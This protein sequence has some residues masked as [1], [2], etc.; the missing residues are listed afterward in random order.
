MQQD[1]DR[2]PLG[3]CYQ[4]GFKYNRDYERTYLA[5]RTDAA[6]DTVPTVR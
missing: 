5:S 1:L 2:M 4:D 6:I 3:F